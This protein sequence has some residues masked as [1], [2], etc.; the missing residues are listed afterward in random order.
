MHTRE[1]LELHIGNNDDNHNMTITKKSVYELHQQRLS[2]GINNEDNSLLI[3][4]I[5]GGIDNILTNYLTDKNN[6]N[7]TNNT[8]LQ[9][10]Q[11]LIT[12]QKY[13]NANTSK[14]STKITATK[15]NEQTDNSFFY[16]FN[17]NNTFLH[18]VFGNEK[19]EKILNVIHSKITQYIISLS[20]IIWIILI[21]IGEGLISAIYFIICWSF[22]TIPYM[23]FWI[24]SSNRHAFYL[25]IKSFEFWLRVVYGAILAILIGIYYQHNVS[26]V[27][28]II[29]WIYNIIAMITIILTTIYISIFDAVKITKTYKIAIS[30]ICS[31]VMVF[32]SIYWQFLLS[33]KYDYIV[34][35]PV[36][37]GSLSFYSMISSAARILGIF[38]CKQAVLAIIR[39]EK[40][41]TIKHTP[42]IKW[43]NVVENKLQN[44]DIE[45]MNNL[46][47][48]N[49]DNND[50]LE[51]KEVQLY[52]LHRKNQSIS[53]SLTEN[54]L[55]DSNNEDTSIV[56][57]KKQVINNEK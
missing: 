42:I 32:T 8:L 13:K 14:T 35:I 43:N 16:T 33:E 34:Y 3:M 50:Q 31:G 20:V 11:M 48:N 52:N 4:N 12:P 56:I 7:I 47:Y 25:I 1:Q 28:I 53:L 36:T 23:L 15:H 9:I 26:T 22:L 6:L 55:N 54:S 19:A 45:L 30:V 57:E 49:N 39:N 5:L 2:N 37:N 18:H 21:I 27:N 40:A 44:K 46:N 10:N 29:Y 51:I 17:I 24:L 41:V 38:F